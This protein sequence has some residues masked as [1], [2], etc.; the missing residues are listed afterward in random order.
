M[1]EVGGVAFRATIMSSQDLNHCPRCGE[2]VTA[3]AAGCSYCGTEL[4][5]NRFRKP[6]G[7]G[8]QVTAQVR[9]WVRRV[10]PQR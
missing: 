3:F 4:D 8:Q 2:R 6:H 9:S 7:P 5:T 10:K 1:I